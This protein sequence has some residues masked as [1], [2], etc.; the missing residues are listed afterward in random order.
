MTRVRAVL[1]DLYDTLVWTDWPKLRA[2]LEEELG[3]SRDDLF[4]AFT[5][6]RPARS[7][8]AF[9]SAEGDVGAVLEAAGVR[10]DGD[11]LTDVV[12]R[13]Q[14][15]LR[16]G[17]TLHEDAV[18]TLR[19]LRGRGI[20]TAVVSNCDHLTG[21]VVERLGLPEEADAV[22]LSY[23][24][25][26]AKPDPAI[27]RAALERLGVEPEEAV[28]VDDQAA[29]CDGAARVGIPTFLLLREG[30]A[31]PEGTSGPGGHR[32]I[33]NLRPLLELA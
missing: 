6:T 18:P 2:G 4:R 24:I 15:F 12:D 14:R 8:G 27:Y 23:E 28:F 5:V 21:P 10:L 29:Y 17:V 13:M 25:G 3:V 26:S 11:G 22:V 20:G 16:T 9:G 32:V 1:L 7:V 33:R 31:P 19:T 30:A